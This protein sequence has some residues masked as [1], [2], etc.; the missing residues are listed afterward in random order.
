MYALFLCRNATWHMY[1]LVLLAWRD[2][3]A[4]PMEEGSA[5]GGDGHIWVT[6][7][8]GAR[9]FLKQSFL[10]RERVM[11]LAEENTPDRNTT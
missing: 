4:T 3:K 9:T 8:G 2:R 7:I 6:S 1:M 10:F 11:L 5:V